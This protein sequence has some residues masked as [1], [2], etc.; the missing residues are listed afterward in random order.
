VPALDTAAKK[1]LVCRLYDAANRRDIDGALAQIHPEMEL[2]LALEL[3]ESVDA[4]GR[5]ELRGRD[6]VRQF[7]EVLADS[8][9]EVTTEITDLVEGRDGYLLSYETWRVRGSQGIV[10]D[11][12]MV[13]VYGFRDGL[14][15][16]CD[17]FRDKN[18]A[19]EAF[20]KAD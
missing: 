6:G 8:W 20:G 3:V 13:D 2:R 17:G 18:E 16:S 12:E 9:E 10:I 7:F 15:A 11:T 5:R 19:L 4:G 1:E 14:L